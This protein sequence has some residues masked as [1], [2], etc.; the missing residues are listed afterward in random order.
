MRG[1]VD[2]A[3]RPY[4]VNEALVRQLISQGN[5][6][7]APMFRPVK[8]GR[9]SAGSPTIYAMARLLCCRDEY[10]PVRERPYSVHDAVVV[11]HKDGPQVHLIRGVYDLTRA[12]AEGLL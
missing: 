2:L 12:M 10:A 7:A 9:F 3:N 6:D 5:F 11:D 1:Y 8:Q 4:R